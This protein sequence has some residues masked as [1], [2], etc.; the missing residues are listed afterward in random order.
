MID[1][2][3]ILLKGKKVRI[4]QSIEELCMI[5]SGA[6]IGFKPKQI[7]VKDTEWTDQ[8]WGNQ[9]GRLF[10]RLSRGQEIL[11]EEDIFGICDRSGTQRD[12]NYTDEDEIV[13]LA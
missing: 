7:V 9:K 4:A 2:T 11:K 8:G 5:H 1:K 3:P 13:N 12:R 6:T 10:I